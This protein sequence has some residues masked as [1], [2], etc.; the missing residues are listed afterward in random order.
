M[1]DDDPKEALEDRARVLATGLFDALNL[2][3]LLAAPRVLANAFHQQKKTPTREAFAKVL[4]DAVKAFGSSVDS[5]GLTQ[6]LC[7]LRGHVATWEPRS[8]A[9]EPIVHAARRVLQALNIPEP[10]E[11]WDRW[12]GPSEEPEP[13]PPPAMPRILR[14]EPMTI[15]EWLAHEGPGELVDG[16][17]I[18]E[19]IST[20]REDAIAAWFLATLRDWAIPRGGVVHGRGHKL[21][22]SHATG[23]KPDVCVYMPGDPSKKNDATSIPA[24]ILEVFTRN[25]VDLR[26]VGQHAAREY[27]HLGVRWYWRLDSVSRVLEFAEIGPEGYCMLAVIADDERFPAP[28]LDGLTIDLAALWATVDAPTDPPPSG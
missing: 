12:E 14:A 24:L 16:F 2:A 19:K 13:P 18:A 22:V 6:A 8:P 28:S 11:G 3:G 25:Q 21:A 15:D 23:R 7:E 17:L 4:E 27:A 5:T 20:P 1:A 9:P 10:D 26:R